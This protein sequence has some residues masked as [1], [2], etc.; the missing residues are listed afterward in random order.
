MTLESRP[1]GVLLDELEAKTPSPGGGAVASVVGALATSLGNMVLAYSTSSRK[2]AEH[3]PVLEDASAKL[4]RARDILLRLADEDA[5]AYAH[6]NATQRLPADDP[7]RAEELPAAALAA[8][9]APLSVLATCSDLLRLLESLVPITNRYL[10]SDLA[11]A[12]VLAD[13]AACGAHWNVRVNLPLLEELGL[14]AGIAAEADALRAEA[15]P[16]RVRIE[17]GCG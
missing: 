2:L 14:Q 4:S 11:I 10:A 12:A 1:L 3:R 7:R 15:G 17:E 6:L 9:Q 5:A 8:T 13:A 16:R